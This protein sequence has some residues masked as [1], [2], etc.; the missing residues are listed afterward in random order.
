VGNF[1]HTEVKGLKMLK[2]IRIVVAVIVAAMSAIS[3]AAPAQADPVTTAWV[4]FGPT[5]NPFT[6]GT[7]CNSPSHYI[8]T[9]A[10]FQ[11]LITNMASGGT[12]N[13]C[14]DSFSGLTI[15]N[16][17]ITIDKPLNIVG[18]HSSNR[19]QFVSNSSSS[20]IFRIQTGAFGDVVRLENLTFRYT[21]TAINFAVNNPGGGAVSVL[22]GQLLAN[23]VLFYGF[24]VT[25]KGGAL[26]IATTDPLDRAVI[27]NSAF[28]NNTAT[29][30]GAVYVKDV[31]PTEINNVGV[32]AGGQADFINVTFTENTAT[33]KGSAVYAPSTTPTMDSFINLNHTTIVDNVA[34][35]NVGVL[36]GSGIQVSNSIVAQRL[37]SGALCNDD[38]QIL[39][40]NLVTDGDSCNVHDQFTSGSKNLSRVVKYSDLALGRLTTSGDVIPYFP[41]VQNLTDDLNDPTYLSSAAV[42]YLET[43]AGAND[44]PGDSLDFDIVGTQ[45]QSVTTG[46]LKDVGA[47]EWAP[48]IRGGLDFP[49]VTHSGFIK[50]QNDQAGENFVDA[51]RFGRSNYR[52]STQNFNVKATPSSVSSMSIEYTSLTPNLCTISDA[53]TLESFAVPTGNSSINGYC[54]IEAY[55]PASFGSGASEF[56]QF[57]ELRIYYGTA[58]TQP[59]DAVLSAGETAISVSFQ[60]PTDTGAGIDGY[61]LIVN[62]ANSFERTTACIAETNSWSCA[63]DSLKRATSYTATL[64][65]N[66]TGGRQTF[67]TLGT[68]KTLQQRQPSVVTS[69]TAKATPKAGIT[70]TWKKPTIAGRTSL[71]TYMVRLYLSTNKTKAILVKSLSLK[72]LKYVFTKL[73]AKKKYIV[74]IFAYNKDGYFSKVEKTITVK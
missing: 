53:N 71:A 31:L 74:K 33:S 56:I 26:S 43:A 41:I 13:I 30:G 17:S 49:V 21:G 45:R 35:A 8:N 52:I 64:I 14:G 50:S 59:R 46:T 38:A 55:A 19:P 48:T 67:F 22:R 51:Y 27:R 60:P 34:A 23:E 6:A 12:I 47:F 40:G 1:P 42:D 16:A 57:I 54:I 44:Y 20:S 9:V 36:S 65:V 62:G 39:F 18:A 32:T 10:A 24:N 72:T 70:V 4:Q 63:V 11:T 29:A 2:P 3:L 61:T 69:V 68:T 28:T 7:S 73:K 5:P 15:T 58:P 66:S 25:G 37:V